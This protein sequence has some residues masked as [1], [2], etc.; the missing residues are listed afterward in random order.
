MEISQ[1]RPPG[2]HPGQEEAPDWQAVLTPLPHPT[3]LPREH[4]LMAEPVMGCGRPKNSRAGRRWAA[5]SRGHTHSCHGCRTTHHTHTGPCVTEHV[6]SHTPEK[7][8]LFVLIKTPASKSTR[9]FSQNNRK[10]VR[11]GLARQ[12][13]APSPQLFHWPMHFPIHQIS[14]HSLSVPISCS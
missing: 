1:E 10:E 14:F 3:P 9:K 13:K 6:P 12:E 5:H 11:T 4:W 8:R 2:L 7:K